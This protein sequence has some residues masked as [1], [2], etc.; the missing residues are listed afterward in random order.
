MYDVMHTVSQRP[1][2]FFFTLDAHA[3]VARSD[4]E[5]EFSVSQWLAQK[6]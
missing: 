2:P 5:P 1:A 6:G 4:S 3:A